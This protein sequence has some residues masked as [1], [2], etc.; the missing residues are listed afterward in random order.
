MSGVTLKPKCYIF[1]CVGC[2][3]LAC[4]GRSDRL[5]CS[6]RCRVRAHRNGSLKR[7]RDLAAL[8]TF[9]IEPASIQQAAAVE[10]L[11]PDL[12][13]KLKLGQ[14]ELQ[15]TRKEMWS[16]FWTLLESSL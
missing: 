4:S 1:V 5:T 9:D 10:Q 16:A 14:M 15:D 12:A 2:G 8:P 6:P 7:L 3:L 11:R 13:E